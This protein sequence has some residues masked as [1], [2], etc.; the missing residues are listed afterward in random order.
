MSGTA[1]MSYLSK[2]STEIY[3]AQ[4]A[5]ALLV[6]RRGTP[7]WRRIS[8]KTPGIHFC[9]ES[10]Y[11]SLV[12]LYTFTLTPHLILEMFKLLKTLRRGL[13]LKHDSF[14]TAPS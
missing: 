11:F 13:F 5:D 8:K 1:F 6:Y 14:V 7:I 3:R 2:R 10:D 12:S 9:Y 4:Y